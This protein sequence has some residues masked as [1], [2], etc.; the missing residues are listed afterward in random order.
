MRQVKDHVSPGFAM[1]VPTICVL[2]STL[3]QERVSYFTVY[4]LLLQNTTITKH[5]MRI[6]VL[7]PSGWTK[8]K[9]LEVD[10]GILNSI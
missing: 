8:S 2:L 1:R 7:K 10:E 6:N 5:N 3:F 9:K 4:M